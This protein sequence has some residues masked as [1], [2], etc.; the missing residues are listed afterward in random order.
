[1]QQYEI[2]SDER[3]TLS[4]CI[5]TYNRGN[6]LWNLLNEFDKKN[7]FPFNFEV[8]VLDNNSSDVSYEKISQFKSFNYNYRYYKNLKNIG[9]ERN[10][11]TIYRLANAEFCL[12]L[13]DDDRLLRDGLVHAVETMISE[14]ELLALFA[15][16]Q[17]SGNSDGIEQRYHGYRD[18]LVRPGEAAA[19]AESLSRASIPTP[20]NALFRTDAISHAAFVGPVNYSLIMLLRHLLRLGP[21]RFSSQPFYELVGEPSLK[22]SVVDR[23]SSNFGFESWGRLARAWAVFN[24]WATGRRVFETT[25]SQEQLIYLP[26]LR[27]AA[28]EAQ[29]H[30][31]YH[32]ALEIVEHLDSLASTHG[33]PGGYRDTLLFPA[34]IWASLASISMLPGVEFVH[35]IGLS[36]EI[37]TQIRQQVM[38]QCPDLVI[39]SSAFPLGLSADGA[40]FLTATDLQREQIIRLH[41]ALPGYVLSLE[42]LRR[43]FDY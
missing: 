39:R 37:E 14:P 3:L 21:V 4:I 26:Y 43:A 10:F 11:L 24:H 34:S 36:A 2:E 23:A 41:G 1:M 32:E 12:H 27:N 40:A 25:A 13:C 16:W 42:S 20:E 19:L 31:R 5:P 7:F 15:L 18:M 28:Y 22:Q 8:V 33:I 29:N 35:L 9:A 17:Y 30:G 38:A 6:L